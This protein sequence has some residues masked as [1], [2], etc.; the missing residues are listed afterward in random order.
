M[1]YVR[2]RPWFFQLLGAKNE[3]GKVP[4]SSTLYDPTGIDSKEMNE[5]N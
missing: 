3:A 1:F 2:N 4:T 5:L